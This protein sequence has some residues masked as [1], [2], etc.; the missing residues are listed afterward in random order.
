[1]KL[2]TQ[3][4]YQMTG[5]KPV[6]GRLTIAWHSRIFAARPPTVNDPVVSIDNRLNSITPETP[7]PD[8][9]GTGSGNQPSSHWRLG[10]RLL[11][12]VILIV[13]IAR[14]VDLQEFRPVLQDARL[15]GVLASFGLIMLVR[16][17]MAWRLQLAARQFDLHPGYHASWAM[18]NTS[19]LAGFVLPGG[20]AQDVV[21]GVQLNSL[22]GRPRAALSAMLLDKYFGIIAILPLGVMALAVVGDQLPPAITLF[23]CL[24]LAGV[25]TTTVLARPLADLLGKTFSG[26][27]RLERWLDLIA[28]H[29]GL[30]PRFAGLF[31]LSLLIQV[32]R[33]CATVALFYAFSVG[34]NPWLAFVYVPIVV[35]VIIAPIS[36][37]GLGV[38]E[39][40]LLALFLPLGADAERLVLVGFTSMLLELASSVHGFWYIVRGLPDAAAQKEQL[41]N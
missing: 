7:T 31:L 34:I 6:S 38:R 22:F 41:G 13:L 2:Q 35:I 19:S 24:T 18:L 40:V 8:P 37:G 23:F 26:S 4:K 3:L 15:S 12:A 27:E 29:I 33:C 39:G 1:M 11:G 30:S 36:L 9:K 20:L 17:A 16:F 14:E 25:A 10:L 5:S 32:L 21:R 28:N